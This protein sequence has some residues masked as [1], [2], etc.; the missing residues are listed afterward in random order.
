MSA[1]DSP[2]RNVFGFL[3]VFLVSGAIAAPWFVENMLGLTCPAE[4]SG[5]YFRGI[6]YLESA[7]DTYGFYIV[8]IVAACALYLVIREI[9]KR[10]PF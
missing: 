3:A 8:N 2:I 6:W 4:I 10:L 1:S 5:W 9:G 7:T